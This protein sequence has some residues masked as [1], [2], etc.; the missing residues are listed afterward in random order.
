MRAISVEQEITEQFLRLGSERLNFA[1][2]ELYAQFAKEVDFEWGHN[3][4]SGE[5]CILFWL[6]PQRNPRPSRTDWSSS[7]GPV[8]AVGQFAGDSLEAFEASDRGGVRAA[9]ALISSGSAQ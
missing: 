4:T 5:L 7:L 2:V 3:R 9:A 6:S 1:V 8:D